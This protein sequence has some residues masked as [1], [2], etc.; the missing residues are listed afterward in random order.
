MLEYWVKIRLLISGIY[1]FKVTGG[2]KMGADM[3]KISSAHRWPPNLQSRELLI[4]FKSSGVMPIYTLIGQ[5]YK[6]LN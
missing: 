5:L 6:H 2:H 1:S 4:L 3:R